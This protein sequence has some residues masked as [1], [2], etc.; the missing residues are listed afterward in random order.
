[1]QSH[2]NA[3]QTI[4]D[5]ETASL[6]NWAKGDPLGF[7]DGFADD[8]TYFDD[9]AAHTRLDG[10]TEIQAHLASLEGKIS[11][12]EFEIV[13]PKVQVYGDIAILTLQYHSTVNDTIKGQPWKATSVYHFIDDDWK[14][15]HA[16]WSLVKE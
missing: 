10:K 14:V 4:I 8:A 2:E 13:D 5:K 15:V 6:E 1:M 16:H 3:E 12:H 9:I 11:P 7:L